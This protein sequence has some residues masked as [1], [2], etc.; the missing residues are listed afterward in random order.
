MA[1]SM[2]LSTSRNSSLPGCAR[3]SD[4]GRPDKTHMGI[5]ASATGHKALFQPRDKV[6]RCYSRLAD[7]YALTSRRASRR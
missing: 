3:T 7:I 4:D 6:S 5:Q 2:R 1:W